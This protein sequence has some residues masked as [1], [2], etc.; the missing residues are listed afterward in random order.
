MRG[1][2]ERSY[3]ILGEDEGERAVRPYGY[4]VNI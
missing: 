1:V 4:F 2:T 3:D